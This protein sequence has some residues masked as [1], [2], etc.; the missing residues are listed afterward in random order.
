MLNCW[1][2]ENTSFVW[3]ESQRVLETIKDRE[4]RDISPAL[5]LDP[6]LLWTFCFMFHRVVPS[7]A[8]N[9]S[10]FTKVLGVSQ[11]TVGLPPYR[12]GPLFNMYFFE[13][14][15]IF[16]SSHSSSCLHTLHS[17]PSFLHFHP[18]LHSYYLSSCVLP[19]FS[20]NPDCCSPLVAWF[21][22]VLQT[23]ASPWPPCFH[24]VNLPV[25]PGLSG[26]DSGK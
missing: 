25:N 22:S 19:S 9:F 6:S 17:F 10:F 8:C 12:G 16:S 4:P 1:V 20:T 13:A 7:S 11:T 21:T 15:P 3:S 24:C 2:G 26:D 5:L 23:H 18:L 14:S